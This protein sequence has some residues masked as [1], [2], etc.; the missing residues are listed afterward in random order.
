MK[1][2]FYPSRRKVY[3]ALV[4]ILA[5][6]FARMLYLEFQPASPMPGAKATEIQTFDGRTWTVFYRISVPERREPEI[7]PN[8]SFHYSQFGE[9]EILERSAHPDNSIVLWFHID[10]KYKG[11][12]A[13][14]GFGRFGLA[15]DIQNPFLHYIANLESPSNELENILNQ[16]ISKE[17]GIE[18]LLGVWQ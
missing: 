16:M 10:S 2:I 17:G 18:R 1:H 12:F 4:T 5:L 3:V 7:L 14:A 6:V 15:K 11:G 13:G 8:G 9:I